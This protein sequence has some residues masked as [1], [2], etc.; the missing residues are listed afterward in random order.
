MPKGVQVCVGCAAMIN[1]R[2]E[3][4]SVELIEWANKEAMAQVTAARGVRAQCDAA[5]DALTSK[6]ETLQRNV[7]EVT[8]KAN[9]IA[10]SRLSCPRERMP[11]GK[12]SKPCE[13]REASP[14]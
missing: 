9:A 6:E 7:E 10:Y 4:D 8:A 2:I 3:L 13:H 12:K 14:T 5:E 1:E 11:R